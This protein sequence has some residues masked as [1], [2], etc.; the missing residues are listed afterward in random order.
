MEI[1]FAERA[2]RLLED[3]GMDVEY[4]EDDY[5]HLI[6]PAHAAAAARWLATA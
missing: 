4:H 1:G 3:A 5:G 6:E 2:R